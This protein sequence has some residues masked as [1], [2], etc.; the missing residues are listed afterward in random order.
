[1]YHTL[2]ASHTT[3]STRERRVPTQPHVLKRAKQQHFSH[4]FFIFLFPSLADGQLAHEDGFDFVCA[5][6]SHPRNRR[7]VGVAGAEGAARRDEPWTRSDMVL[8]SGHWANLVVGKLSPWVV[9]ALDAPH[10]GVRANASNVFWQEVHWA[11]HLSLPALLLPAPRDAAH[12]A[13]YAHFVNEVAGATGTA[14]GTALWLRVRVGSCGAARA[15]S[16]EKEGDEDEEGNNDASSW[17]TWNTVRLMCDSSSRLGVVLELAA[18]L[19]ESDA[20]LTRWCAEP[21]R[22]VVLSTSL[23]LTNAAGLPVLSRRHQSF[24]RMLVRTM[25]PQIVLTG[26]PHHRS[27]SSS[28]DGDAKGCGMSAYMASVRHMVAQCAP[29]TALE[30]FEEPYFDVLQVPLQPLGDNL[31][32]ATYEVFEKD[33]VKYRRYEEATHAALAD[34]KAA[35]HALPVVVMV[36]G[37]GRGPLVDRALRAAAAA[38]VPVRVYAVEKN[39]NALVTLRRKNQSPPW[40]GVVTVVESDMRVWDA[41]EKADILISELLGSFGDNELSP[42]CLDGAQK[43]L[44]PDGISIP[45]EYTSYAT[46]ISTTKLHTEIRAQDDPERKLQMPYV[47]RLHQF[48]AL[49]ETQPCF[50]FR[51]P[52]WAENIDNTRYACLS[53]AAGTSALVHGFAGYFRAM[54][55]KDI[56]ISIDPR[57]FSDGMF[58]WFPVFFPLLRPVVVRRGDTVTLHVW[59]QNSVSAVWYEWALATENGRHPTVIHNP[60][61]CAY[62]IH[63]H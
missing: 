62:S 11:Q 42:E 41:P 57:T 10:G 48:N 44:K 15:P 28:S 35:G 40:H 24:L 53:F 45:Y 13:H 46:P 8:T 7:H 60:N 56:D 37:A 32:S 18:D 38:D 47:V 17:E 49:A 31:E 3:L 36:V 63:L 52:N 54:L 29:P 51:H 14:A 33:P 16:E 34:L 22:A 25:N 50:T 23:F 58:S 21:C 9:D 6:L 4:A 26:N 43:F 1:M 27:S 19:P 12:C 59:R 61:G 2:N 39:P 5:P 55:Y 30:Q 20:E